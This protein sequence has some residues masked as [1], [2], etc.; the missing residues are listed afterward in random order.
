[1]LN[2]GRW[3]LCKPHTLSLVC[4]L[5]RLVSWKM[6]IN[7]PTEMK[8]CEHLWFVDYDDDS[9][10]NDGHPIWLRCWFVVGW[11]HS[12]LLL[13]VVTEIFIYEKIKAKYGW[14]GHWTLDTEHTSQLQRNI[15]K[16]ND[17][18]IQMLFVVPVIL[19]SGGN[20]QQHFTQQDLVS[21]IT[22]W[23]RCDANGTGS[24]AIW[25]MME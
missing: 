10:D 1:M 5:V 22:Y 18:Y 16:G 7:L 24:Y 25:L 13:F 21:H 6:R 15:C 11:L 9:V 23:M 17:S 12:Q 4:R 14:T 20:V 2:D 8:I 3:I 19:V